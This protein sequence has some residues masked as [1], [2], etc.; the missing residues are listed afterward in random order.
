MHNNASR[1]NNKETALAFLRRVLPR[2]GQ[3][4]VTCERPGK[5]EPDMVIHCNGGIEV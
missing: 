3:D 4:L 5:E 2:R 1:D